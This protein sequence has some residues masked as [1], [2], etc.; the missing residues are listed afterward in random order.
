MIAF[1][2]FL[3]RDNECKLAHGAFCLQQYLDVDSSVLKHI[4]SYALFDTRTHTVRYAS[5]GDR[6]ELL[7]FLFSLYPVEP[8]AEA[9]AVAGQHGSLNVLKYLLGAEDEAVVRATVDEENALRWACMT[10]QLDAVKLLTKRVG[11]QKRHLHV[12]LQ[13]AVDNGSL[14][15][16]RFLHETC[17]ADNLDGALLTAMDNKDQDIQ[18]IVLYLLESGA[19][20]LRHGVIEWAA[21]EGHL[22]LVNYMVECGADF[23]GISDSP[24]RSAVQGGHVDVARRLLQLG[25]DVHIFDESPLRMASVQNDTDMARLLIE[26]GAIVDF[27]LQEAVSRGELFAIE[28]LLQWPGADHS[29]LL[30][31]ATDPKVVNFLIEKGVRY[32][33]GKCPPVQS[34]VQRR[35]R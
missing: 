22:E 27:A 26:Y 20:G 25:A 31:L 17:G 18:D 8:R 5:A 14:D 13:I 9:L 21:M 19:D 10:R 3:T 28:F 34:R 12:P 4:I 16:V 11:F 35:T 23:H 29:N 2:E 33:I 30:S 6:P 15:I 24:L 7:K 32:S 1:K